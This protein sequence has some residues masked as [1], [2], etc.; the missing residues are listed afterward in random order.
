MSHVKTRFALKA[1]W[2]VRLG[3]ATTSRPDF[4]T[5]VSRP[6]R[7][8]LL[9]WLP[10]CHQPPTTRCPVPVPDG[11]GPMR[12]LSVPCGMLPNIDT[13]PLVA[14]LCLP[15][16]HSGLRF[17]LMPSTQLPG[18]SWLL[19]AGPEEHAAQ[20]ALLWQAGG[21]GLPLGGGAAG[22][23]GGAAISPLE[24]AGQPSAC[25]G[26]ILCALSGVGCRV[27]LRWHVSSRW[28]WAACQVQPC[29]VRRA[30]AP[31]S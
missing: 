27:W 18:C 30:G 1:G 14:L 21:T 3:E 5:E 29:A 22:A 24:V 6:Q 7:A 10:G 23:A 13:T 17:R 20:R 16:I 9:G 26:V 15:A 12:H 19:L 2:M 8:G 31:R 28:S 4:G 11:R 25:D